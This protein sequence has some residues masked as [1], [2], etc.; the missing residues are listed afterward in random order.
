MNQLPLDKAL[1]LYDLVGKHLPKDV[2]DDGLL[3]IGGVIDSMIQ[4]NE[5]RNYLMSIALMEQ[6]EETE[7]TDM[8]S[9]ELLEVFADGLMR[10]NI[11]GLRNFCMKIGYSNG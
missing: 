5:H 10:N 7:L 1:K 2:E 8:T 6:C 3:F 9:N 11:L 4:K